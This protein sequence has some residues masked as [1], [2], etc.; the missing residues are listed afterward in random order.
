MLW[1]DAK[2][3]ILLGRLDLFRR[4]KDVLAKYEEYQNSLKRNNI[5]V[6]DV[7]LRKMKGH[8]IAWMRNAF[9][10][11]VENTTHY[12]IWSTHGPLADDKIREI[13]I[14]HSHD[15]EFLYFVNPEHLKSVKDL[16]HAHVFMK[17]L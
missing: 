7:I 5:Q 15:R 12:L 2:L 11:D 4:R 14:R 10:Y 9:P 13:A 16:W 17:N 3:C 6:K 8:P 1:S